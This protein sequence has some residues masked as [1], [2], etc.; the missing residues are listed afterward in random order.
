MTP[1]SC[2]LAAKSSDR[3]FFASFFSPSEWLQ[4]G[5]LLA[6]GSAHAGM[7]QDKFDVKRN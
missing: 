5:G 2:P 1:D 4:S 6:K 7:S 3:S